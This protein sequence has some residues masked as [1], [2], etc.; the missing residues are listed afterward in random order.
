MVHVLSKTRRVIVPNLTHVYMA[1]TAIPFAHQLDHL[2]RF[3]LLNFP[4]E[5]VSLG[6]ISYGGAMAWGMAIQYPHL[7]KDVVLLNPMPPA[8]TDKF[9]IPVLRQFFRLPMTM[10]SVLITLRTPIGRYF[11][12]CASEVFR[13]E[14]AEFW[15]R[16]D[17]LHGR[18]LLFVGHVIERFHWI[19]KNENWNLWQKKLKDI[20]HRVQLLYSPDDNLFSSKMYE[21]FSQF[22]NVENLASIESA[23]HIMTLRR[24]SEIARH[25]DSFLAMDLEKAV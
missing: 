18:K 1:K 14:R 7:V 4:N 13:I 23:G 24:G 22:L 20:P 15:D 10:N 3:L 5:K 17:D 8:P 11:L 9:E 21:Q 2:A 19:L 12:K 6:G 16:F 25:I